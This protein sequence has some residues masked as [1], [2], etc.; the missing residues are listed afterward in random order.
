MARQ[1][2]HLKNNSTGF[3]IREIQEKF[4]WIIKGT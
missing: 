1:L 2:S 4:V 3:I